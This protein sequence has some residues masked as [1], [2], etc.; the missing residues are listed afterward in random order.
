VK[1]GARESESAIIELL[2]CYMRHDAE[3]PAALTAPVRARIRG[4]LGSDSEPILRRLLFSLR[5]SPR[6]Q[7]GVATREP[8]RRPLRLVAKR[9]ARST[10]DAYA[11]GDSDSPIAAEVAQS[12]CGDVAVHAAEE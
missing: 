3:L 10:C 4:Y 2:Y 6:P 5:V 1:I 8:Q 9:S 7:P 11:R 12:Y